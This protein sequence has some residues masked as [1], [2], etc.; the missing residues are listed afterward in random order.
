MKEVLYR[1]ELGQWMGEQGNGLLKA[2]QMKK[3]SV[4]WSEKFQKKNHLTDFIVNSMTESSWD[5]MKAT[6]TSQPH[7]AYCP[8]FHII[9]EV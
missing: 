5:E 6:G 7:S 2:I 9:S 8:L 3:Q 1:E 4:P